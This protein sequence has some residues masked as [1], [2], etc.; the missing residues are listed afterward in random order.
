MW[1]TLI[2]SLKYYS[3]HLRRN[4]TENLT[5]GLKNQRKTRKMHK[6]D[7]KMLYQTMRTHTNAYERIR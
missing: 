7:G 6:K 4:S 3:R 2:L 1:I 5:N